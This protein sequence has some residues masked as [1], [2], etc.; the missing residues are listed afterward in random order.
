[1]G[2]GGGG[3]R[4]SEFILQKNPNLKKIC[5]FFWGGG[6]GRVEGARVSDLSDFY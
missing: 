2:W 3:V 4:A 1:M 5:F 6:G